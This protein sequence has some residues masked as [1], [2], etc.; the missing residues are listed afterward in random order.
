MSISVTIP[1][2]PQPDGGRFLP[3]H[4]VLLS[5]LNVQVAFPEA[6]NVHEIDFI[7]AFEKSDLAEI[8][9]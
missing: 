8:Y 5:G 3:I 9:S 6:Y 7:R 4:A 1:L 2:V